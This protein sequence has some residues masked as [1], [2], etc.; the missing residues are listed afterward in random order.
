MGLFFKNAG[1]HGAA[2][3]SHCLRYAIEL[4]RLEVIKLITD[5]NSQVAQQSFISNTWKAKC[6]TQIDLLGM[7]AA[8][9]ALDVT[10][11]EWTSGTPNCAFKWRGE[12]A[13]A[14]FNAY[15]TPGCLVYLLHTKEV[16]DPCR[17]YDCTTSSKIEISVSDL[18]S[19]EAVRSKTLLPYNPMKL[20]D[21]YKDMYSGARWSTVGKNQT[22]HNAF[23]AKMN[24]WYS[25]L[26]TFP[27]PSRLSNID[28][29]DDMT[30]SID[31]QEDGGLEDYCDMMTD[32]F[33]EQ[34]EYPAGYHPT[35]PCMI[36]RDGAPRTY[37]QVF[38]YKADTNEMV[39]MPLEMRDADAVHNF[40][41]VEGICR[42]TNYDLDMAEINT[43]R[44][45]TRQRM[46]PAHD[47][48]VPKSSYQEYDESLKE[49]GNEYC[50]TSSSDVPWSLDDRDTE[51]GMT[52]KSVLS[53]GTILLNGKKVRLWKIKDQDIFGEH[54]THAK[55]PDPCTSDSQCASGYKCHNIG[56]ICVK[57]DST[58]CYVH[59][60]CTADQLMCSG[61]FSIFPQCHLF[62][63]DSFLLTSI[64]TIDHSWLVTSKVPL[65]VPQTF[66]G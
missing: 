28:M 64:R 44:I 52:G 45:C 14:L 60:D 39:Y 7:C 9:K 19:L 51:I 62:M 29:L 55:L 13:Y 33:P 32:W 54:C 12:T 43:A 16:H 41:G 6:S 42:A 10:S 15:I 53:M 58:K 23:L 11:S 46:N 36:D 57:T 50:A 21:V 63:F 2:P 3:V 40:F 5:D 59:S 66:R 37:D 30:K 22:L 34:F 20:V 35:L 26:T 24:D 48:S 47:P 18:T 49:W 61:M 17:Y 27:I 25:S 38:A 4:A 65:V 1:V 8:T 31:K 56:K